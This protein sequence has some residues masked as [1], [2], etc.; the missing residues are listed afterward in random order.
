M[1]EEVSLILSI[2]LSMFSP[3]DSMIWTKES[4][5]DFTTKRAYFVERT[6][7]GLGGEELVG[8]TP[9]ADMKFL[10]KALW[11][12]KVLGKVKIC[13]WCGCMNALP[14]KV[15][16][17]VLWNGVD[18]SPLDVQ[19]KA[20]TWLSEFKKWNVAKMLAAS[21]HDL[22][23]KRPDFGWINRCMFV[24]QWSTKQVQFESG[25]LLV[26]TAIHNAGS[27]LHGHLGHLFANTSSSG[28]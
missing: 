12:A 7:H 3:V 4:K 13:V 15:R 8:S 1:E 18:I 10:W 23:W 2:P 14:S 9:N 24:Q 22:K 27:A 5:G 25:A 16:N 28:I 21:V 6:W 26:V 11:R 19:L 17:D 20:Q